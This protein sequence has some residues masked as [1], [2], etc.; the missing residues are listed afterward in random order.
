[1]RLQFFFT[2]LYF[3]ENRICILHI[4]KDLFTS[5][6]QPDSDS[7]PNP[8]KKLGHHFAGNPAVLLRS[9]AFRPYLTVGL[10][11]SANDIATS[12]PNIF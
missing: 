5:P 12:A 4:K 11:L 8:N 7:A 10:A 9:V 1:M 6:F 2:P 3:S